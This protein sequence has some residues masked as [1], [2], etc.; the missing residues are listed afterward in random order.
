[1]DTPPDPDS[2]SERPD[3][4]GGPGVLVH[5]LHEGA[6][7][8]ATLAASRRAA[9][10][11][12]RVVAGLTAT[13]ADPATLTEVAAGLERLADVL[14]PHRAGSR[15]PAS[16]PGGT[17]DPAVWEAHPLL[18]P[19]HPLAPPIR[20]ERH[21]DRAVGTATFGHVY[22]G[23]RGAVHGGIVAAMFDIICIS[24]A[25]IAEVAGLTGTLTVRYRAPTPLFREIRFEA[26]IDEVRARTALVSG[27]STVDG[28]LLAEA[29]GIFVRIP[30][31]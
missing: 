11:A 13:G 27:R 7:L 28:R 18:G 20:I 31:A 26:W 21:G 17:P 5:D 24:A 2:G 9:V 19:S 23:P 10:A 8:P 30:R 25:S 3:G 14:E 12:R 15:W 4:P 29:E 22:E 6:D 1:M 16:V